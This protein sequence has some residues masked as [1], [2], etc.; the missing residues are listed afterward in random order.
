MTTRRRPVIALVVFAASLLACGPGACRT[1]AASRGRHEHA[2][3]RGG[4]L[5]ELGDELAHVELVLDRGQGRLVA[6][7][8]DGKAEA[9]V[10]VAQAQLAVW[11]RRTDRSEVRLLLTPVAN[12]LTGE[13]PGDT[14]QFEAHAE[15]LR[16][17]PELAGRIEELNVK[18]TLFRHV[19]FGGAARP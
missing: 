5:V 6:Y 14:S 1:A 16:G 13:T 7:V 3:P 15:P 4:T 10:R 11:I 2:A 8:L 19:A 17:L 12:P 9:G 18:G